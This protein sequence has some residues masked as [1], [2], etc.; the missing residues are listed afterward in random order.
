MSLTVYLSGHLKSFTGG[1]TEFALGG[2]HNTAGD[3]LDSLWAQCPS[4]RD[5]ILN[6]QGE[7]RRHV[8]IFYDGRDVRRLEGLETELAPE[9]ELHIF[10]AV[11]GG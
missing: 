11:S 2:D 4:L 5:R 9:A 10:N 6:E 8:N 7:I 3:A 1:T